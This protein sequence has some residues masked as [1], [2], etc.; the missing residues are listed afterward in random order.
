MPTLSSHHG[1]GGEHRPAGRRTRL[2]GVRVPQVRVRD[3]RDPAAEAPALVRARNIAEMRRAAHNQSPSSI[4]QGSQA[5]LTVAAGTRGI[6]T[7][8]SPGWR[9]LQPLRSERVGGPGRE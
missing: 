2:D 8:D 1:R 3:E 5:K 7:V 4:S 6:S 9:G